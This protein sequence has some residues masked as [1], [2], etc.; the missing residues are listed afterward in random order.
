MEIIVKKK[1]SKAIKFK[2]LKYGDIFS[3]EENQSR[4]DEIFLKI[5]NSGE[6]KYG[7]LC[8]SNF[9]TYITFDDSD[10]YLIDSTLT[11]YNE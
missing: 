4:E 1:N 3:Y 9:R 2:D 11:L 7:S 8:I 5:N 6:G 10:C